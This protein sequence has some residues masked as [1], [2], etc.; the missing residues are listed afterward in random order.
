MNKNISLKESIAVLIVL[1][2]LLGVLI[3]GFQLST[4]PDPKLS[5]VCCFMADLKVHMG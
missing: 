2:A 1:L 4:Y 3:I 5:C